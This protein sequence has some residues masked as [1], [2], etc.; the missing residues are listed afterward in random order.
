VSLLLGE[1]V[2]HETRHD[3]ESIFYVI[4]WACI[5]LS[6]PRGQHR[7]INIHSTALNEWMN[8][9]D[10]L[11]ATHKSGQIGLENSFGRLLEQFH[12]YFEPLKEMIRNLRDNFINGLRWDNHASYKSFLDA[13]KDTRDRLPETEDNA[14][15]YIDRFA[16][17]I[18][19]D[20]AQTAKD[21]K[22]IMASGESY[23]GILKWQWQTSETPSSMQIALESGR[24]AKR[25]RGGA[26]TK[27]GSSRKSG[28][29]R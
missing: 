11:C 24:P 26:T 5:T 23:P 16:E 28:S 14:E 19:K 9:D 12:P 2:E 3:L 17:K 13:L 18:A 21:K 15:I 27:R 8:G 10:E 1:D 25:S 22:D 20:A 4:I 29:N 7:D 6:G